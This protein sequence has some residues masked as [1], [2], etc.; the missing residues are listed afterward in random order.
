MEF[1][2]GVSL[3]EASCS[4]EVKVSPGVE[5][6]G[7][8]RSEE[9]PSA[10]AETTIEVSDGLPSGSARCIAVTLS[11]CLLGDFAALTR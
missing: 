8:S 2:V 9:V 3:A 10:I 5:V 6:D 1:G 4:S 7:C 11:V